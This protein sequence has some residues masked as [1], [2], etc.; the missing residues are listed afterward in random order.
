MNHKN[1]NR[2]PRQVRL[3][4]QQAAAAYDRANTAVMRAERTLA[5]ATHKRRMAFERLEA[6]FIDARAAY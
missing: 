5:M 1:P 3:T 2:E 6:A 4:M